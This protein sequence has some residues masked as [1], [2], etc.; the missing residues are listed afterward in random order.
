[1][2]SAP[3]IVLIKTS[4]L[5]DVLHNLPVV[6]DICAYLPD[7]CIDWVV[8]ENFAP[9]PALH[10]KVKRVI[11]VAMR[12]WRKSLWQSRGEMRATCRDLR[13]SH[14]DYALDTQGLLKSALIARCVF[15]KRCGFDRK[16]AREPLASLFYDRTY[17][18]AKNLHAVER[19][20]QLAGQA[21]G[22]VPQGAPDYGIRAPA[23]GL[24][25]MPPE[26]YAVLLHATSRDE[27]LWDEANWIALGKRL[28]QTGMRIVLPW[29]SATE[30]ARS[31]RLR[32][33]IPGAVCPPAIRLDEAAALLGR[34]R[35]AIGVDTGLSH[36]AAAFGVPTVGIYTATDPG[37]TGLHAGGS[38]INLGGKQQPPDVEQVMVALRQ[39]G[40]HE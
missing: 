4:S 35:A 21:L 6:S 28:G 23:L 2:Q 9:L 5:G 13:A 15:A 1:M 25:W 38:A 26:P 24:P 7:A 8:E 18:V 32:A 17:F 11:P 30:Q 12:R 33:V 22:Y 10:S 39:A 27:K 3:N 31:E 34:A 14:Y 20:R 19:N 36:L 16:S 29:G 40:L 37:L